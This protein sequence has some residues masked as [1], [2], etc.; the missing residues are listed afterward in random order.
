MKIKSLLQKDSTMAFIFLLPNLICFLCFIL[1]P[2]LYSFVLSFMK[3]DI[4]SAPSFVGLDNFIRLFTKDPVFQQVLTNTFIFVLF[5]VPGGTIISLFIALLLNQ[6]IIGK[7]IYRTVFFLPVISS[8]VIVAML[9]K[10]LLVPDFG[11]VN[12][13]LSLFSI[14]GPNWLTDP[15]WALPSV[16]MVSIWKG[17]GFNMLI[18]LAGLQS[19][20]T[21]YYEAVEIDGGN[22]LHK[23]F[24]VTLPL[25]APTTFFVVVMSIIGSFQAFDTV[26]LMTNGGPGRS[27]SVIVH[28]LYQKAFKSFDMGYAAS[29]SYVLFAMVLILTII[30]F[31]INKSEDWTI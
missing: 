3:W 7:R 17:V 14:K 26:N 22:A 28:Y 24:N 13:L 11:L 19:I 31:K 27:T 8:S 9:W 18:F 15:N 25:L 12:Y 1:I 29:I 10:W 21:T 2:I 20:P 5:S 4:L 16:I 30:Q 6:E 23:F